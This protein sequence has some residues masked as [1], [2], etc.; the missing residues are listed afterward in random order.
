MQIFKTTLEL[1]EYLKDESNI[2]LVP[3][4]GNLHQGHL[5]LIEQSTNDNKITVVS[6]YVNPTQFA[7]DEDFDLYPRTL[8][9][10]VAKI[11]NLKKENIIIY[12][13][14]SKFE[15]YGDDKEIYKVTGPT[16]ILEGMV[17]PTH[18]DGVTTVVYHFFSIVK[19]QSAYFG[20]KDYQQLVLVKNLNDEYNFGINIVGMPIVREESGL[21][22]SSRNGLLS[23][24]QR[25]E[26]LILNSSLHKVRDIYY[27]TQ[28]LE[29]VNKKIEEILIDKRFNY[30]ELREKNSLAEVSA[31]T[32]E[33]V[34][35]GNIKLSNTKLLDNLEF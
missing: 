14:K 7:A 2:G 33:F 21:A 9:D 5:S 22:L 29:L 20:Q 11:S 17:R 25:S 28:N 24:P 26:A 6:I 13:P 32:E 23:E 4:M 19:P 1:K 31:S 35:L 16:Q 15:V 27:S 8:E 34:I 30:L 18:F 3:T 12:A 10:D